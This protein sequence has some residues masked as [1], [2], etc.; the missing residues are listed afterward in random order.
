MTFIF[1]LGLSLILN[2][3][4]TKSNSNHER[5]KI[6]PWYQL[7]DFNDSRNYLV[8]MLPS[9]HLGNRTQLFIKVG[10]FDCFFLPNFYL[11]SIILAFEPI[12][13][14]PCSLSF[15]NS[16]CLNQF[17][18]DLNRSP[19]ICLCNERAFGFSEIETS[20]KSMN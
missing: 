3:K 8:G 6:H 1:G 16:W 9:N 20:I 14:Y 12:Y 15:N 7:R 13:V 5:K 11:P 17:M 19:T 2:I 10:H 18:L 4:I